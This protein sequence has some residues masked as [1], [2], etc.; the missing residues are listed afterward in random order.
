MKMKLMA[1]VVTTLAAAGVAFAQG[2][3]AH[4][5]RGP[6]GRPAGDMGRCHA[7]ACPMFMG[8]DGSPGLML[9][10]RRPALAE[11]VGLTKEEVQKL[12]DLTFDHEKQMIELRANVEQA[13]LSLEKA[14]SEG[15]SDLAEVDKA[16]DEA[17]RAQ[18]EIEKAQYRYQQQ[19]RGIISEE[20]L[21]DLWK[22]A[23]EMR[24]KYREER[25][26]ARARIGKGPGRTKVHRGFFKKHGMPAEPQG[27]G[28]D[29]Q[30]ED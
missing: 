21:E 1:V 19:V 6:M 16:I 29:E 10:I 13:R 15:K 14:K 8:M 11:K 12:R 24:E 4:P 30:D 9:L 7:M 18:A 25:E 27:A 5:P 23:R 22:Q 28:D 3:Q 26:I 20:R 17:H 2:P